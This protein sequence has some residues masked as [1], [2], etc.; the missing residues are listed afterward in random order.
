[1]SYTSQFR[2]CVMLFVVSIMASAVSAQEYGMVD[3]QPIAKEAAESINALSRSVGGKQIIG[4]LRHRKHGDKYELQTTALDGEQRRWILG[5]EQKSGKASTKICITESGLLCPVETTETSKYGVLYHDKISGALG[6]VINNELQKAKARIVEVQ[7]NYS[8]K[9]KVIVVSW[10][11]DDEK[12]TKG[13][14][15]FSFTGEKTTV[16]KDK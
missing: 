5:A 7:I 13:E 3:G 12:N 10:E 6:E 4:S 2:V 8:N 1:M 16:P 11:S 14:F 9:V 15:A